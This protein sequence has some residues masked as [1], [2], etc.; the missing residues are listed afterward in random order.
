MTL[1]HSLSSSKRQVAVKA[2]DPVEPA[3]PEVIARATPGQK[4]SQ[5]HLIADL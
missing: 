1:H 2:F 5:R 3:H 4:A